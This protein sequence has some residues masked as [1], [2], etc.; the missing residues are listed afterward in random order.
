MAKMEDFNLI[1][2]INEY[3]DYTFSLLE[4]MVAIP[5]ITKQ[6]RELATF[7]STELAKIGFTTNLQE[8][9]KERPNVYGI[10]EFNNEGYLLTFSG[11][12]DT[13]PPSSGWNGDPFKA[14]IRDNRIYG[15]GACDMKGG[16]AAILTA[17]KVIIDSKYPLRGK[18]AFSGLIDEEAYSKGAKAFLE[19]DFAKSNWILLGEPHY[20]DMESPIPLGMT[21]KILYKISIKGKAAHAF[22]PECGINAIEEAAKVLTSLD[23]LE[24]LEHPKFGKGSVCPLKIEGGYKKYSLVVPD[25]CSL[26]INR[27]LVPGESVEKAVTDLKKLLENLNLKTEVKIETPPPLYEPY[28]ISLQETIVRSLTKAYKQT[29]GTTPTF[30]YQPGVCDANIFV[31]QGKIPTICLGPKGGN[32]H[33]ANEYVEIKSIMTVVEI[34]VR[35]IV[36]LLASSY[37]REERST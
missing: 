9:E 33:Q 27:L 37:P 18:I 4:K 31:A 5:S 10:H 24:C 26:V 30:A 15:L 21:G 25:K 29:L 22:H 23:S 11:H 7:L 13:V 1:N 19:T 16:I 36:D 12:L 14:Q 6:E 20:G 34:Y 35:I 8:V 17:L 2:R 28:E 32:I 3:K